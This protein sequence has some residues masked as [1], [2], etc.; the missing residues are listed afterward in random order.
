MDEALEVVGHAD[1]GGSAGVEA[2]E[3][4]VAE[5]DLVVEADELEEHVG[6]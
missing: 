4:A 3:A 5:G 2:R 6:Y 1:A